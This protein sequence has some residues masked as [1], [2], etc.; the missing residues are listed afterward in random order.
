M[1]SFSNSG[2]QWWF[3]NARNDLEFE[4]LVIFDS[5]FEERR[6]GKIKKPSSEGHLTQG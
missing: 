6:P 4:K 3:C 5:P 1:T 2:D